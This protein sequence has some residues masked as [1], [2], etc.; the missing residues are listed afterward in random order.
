MTTRAQCVGAAATLGRNRPDTARP[1]RPDSSQDNADQTCHQ[2]GQITQ[3]RR[4][5]RRDTP[6]LPRPD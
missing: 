6:N 4:V 3:I 2:T 1:D 5:T